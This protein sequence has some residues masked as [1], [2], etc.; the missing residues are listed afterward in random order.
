MTS[1]LPQ[2]KYRPL[3]LQVLLFIVTFGIYGLYWF[4]STACELRDA[5]GRSDVSP[6][7]LL[8]LMLV[9]LGSLY[10]C[11]KYS[12]MYEAWIDD[13]FNRW[14]LWVIWIVF[15]PAVWFIVQTELNKKATVGI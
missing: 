12:E 1:M 2:I 7:L 9:P 3:L 10:S 6:G 11:Y 15:S 8:L 13:S 5:T 4:Y 14:L